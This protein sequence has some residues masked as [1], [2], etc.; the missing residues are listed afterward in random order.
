ML[1]SRISQGYVCALGIAAF[2][3]GGCG[4]EQETHSWLAM[5]VNM[6]GENGA[7]DSGA[8]ALD[9]GTMDAAI[10]GRDAGLPTSASS[11]DEI[12]P[13][14]RTS[15]PSAGEAAIEIV[16]GDA[17][18]GGCRDLTFE[19]AVEIDSVTNQSYVR[20]A[21]DRYKLVAGDQ[22]SSVQA[23]DCEF[24]LSIKVPKGYKYAIS[25]VDY[26]ARA[27]LQ[28]GM[29]GEF[30]ARYGWDQGVIRA[31]K[32]TRHRFLGPRGVAA[33]ERTFIIE[34]RIQDVEFSRCDETRRARISTNLALFSPLQREGVL[35]LS[36]ADGVFSMRIY[37]TVQRCDGT[38]STADG[39]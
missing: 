38:E 4:T 16:G 35:A 20:L 6:G 31:T 9:V 11:V 1:C 37:A 15:T 19:G 32:E 24:Y 3:L 39:V 26:A 14:A 10:S 22:H 18:G 12:A 8:A 23:T 7:S 25:R 21:Y 2:T 30:A 33:E 28:V 34:D 17:M 27:V 36:D 5:E 29:R 13:D